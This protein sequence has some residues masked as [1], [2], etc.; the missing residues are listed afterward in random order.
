MRGF[1]SIGLLALLALSGSLPAPA[2]AAGKYWWQ[3]DKSA[4]GSP[5]GNSANAAAAANN[6]GGGGNWNGG[7]AAQAAAAPQPPPRSSNGGGGCGGYGGGG[8]GG[9]GGGSYNNNP[10]PAFPA[11]AANNFRPAP[12]SNNNFQPAPVNN[13][14]FQNVPINN[15]N[16]GQAAPN[17][18]QPQPPQVITT[19][20][21][22]RVDNLP[23]VEFCSGKQS[24][25]WS[26]GQPDTDC[27]G[28][29]LCCF[30]GCGNTCYYGGNGNGT[31]SNNQGGIGSE[32]RRRVSSSSGGVR[33]GAGSAVNGGGRRHGQIR[34][35]RRRR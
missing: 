35:W 7:Q 4:F 13:N 30:D 21:C 3:N 23:P 33:V 22:P 11:P 28:N 14:N 17:Q 18:G 10:T 9:G 31:P 24:N 27:V 1:N 19:G 29:A 34:R 16:R 32:G 12:N 6:G 15:N 2:Q 5:S 26:V 25:C 20:S 8:C